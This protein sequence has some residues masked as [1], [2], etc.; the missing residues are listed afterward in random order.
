MSY[1]FKM[2]SKEVSL[3]LHLY[4]ASVTGQDGFGN[5]IV[6]FG[7]VLVNWICWLFSLTLLS[8]YLLIGV[9]NYFVRFPYMLIDLNSIDF[10]TFQFF[11]S[12][13]VKLVFLVFQY[14]GKKYLLQSF[15]SFF[16]HCGSSTS[17]AWFRMVCD[18]Q[19]LGGQKWLHWYV[20]GQ[21]LSTGTELL[22]VMAFQ[23]LLLPEKS[24]CC[25][26]V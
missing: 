24:R 12:F 19:P 1:L 3:V 2:S 14:L 22:S 17:F 26:R 7:S 11:I 13:V 20:L 15:N 21:T 8:C 4:I 5:Q 18:F 10:L 25:T 6:S 9:R 23:E 16:L